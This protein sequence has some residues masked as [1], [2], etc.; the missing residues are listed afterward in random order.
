FLAWAAR[1]AWPTLLLGCLLASVV[2]LAGAAVPLVLG[3]ALD[4]GLADG[5]STRLLWLA[6]ALVGIGL[7][8]AVATS[9]G[10]A[11]EVGGWLHGAFS[12]SRLVGHHVTRTG[13]AIGEELPTGEVV[14]AVA[15]DSFQVGNV[16][17]LL[18]A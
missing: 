8:S 17:E 5:V 15:N 14:S 3:T 18:P 13:P 9:V 16:L 7:L 1:G 11:A 4:S 6:L 12:A 10:H 2:S